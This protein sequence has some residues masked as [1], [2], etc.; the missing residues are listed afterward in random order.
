MLEIGQLI[1][2]WLLS[3]KIV[4][5]STDVGLKK[6]AGGFEIHFQDPFEIHKAYKENPEKS[7]KGP[8]HVISSAVAGMLEGYGLVDSASLYSVI[9]PGH[10][11]TVL[12][13]A[14]LRY[15]LDVGRALPHTQ[16]MPVDGVV[17]MYKNIGQ[18]RRTYCLAQSHGEDIE[19]SRFDG[20][21][22]FLSFRSF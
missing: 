2:S 1:E 3:G 9:D 17:R 4:F 11:A 18:F 19:I 12:S 8:C 7:V 13:F 6:G 10:Y 20:N 21:G 5:D 16:P 14:G 15:V 22:F